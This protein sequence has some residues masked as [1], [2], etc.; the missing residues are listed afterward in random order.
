MAASLAS[1]R[2]A[3]PGPCSAFLSAQRC[4]FGACCRVVAASPT[5]GA[6]PPSSLMAPAVASISVH[7]EQFKFSCAHFVAYRGFRERLHGHNYEVAVRIFGERAA[8]TGYII[9]F[10][11]VKACLRKICTELNERFI[12][13]L[14]SDVIAIE[15]DDASN[16]LCMRCE[17]GAE[18]RMPLTDCALLPIVHSTAEELA[19]F[20]H[21]RL[22]EELSQR[23]ALKSSATPCWMEVTVSER[24]TQAA[25]HAGELIDLR[26][27]AAA[28]SIVLTGSRTS[29][30]SNL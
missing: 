25:A 16:A 1:R 11:V 9:D 5:S 27:P 21:R 17:D 14:Q 22:S 18:F 13:P 6:P 28:G 4:R 2:R 29:R 19:E 12:V 23:S 30:R 3:L 10:G 15:T 26:E 24:P 8:E 20:V 7:G